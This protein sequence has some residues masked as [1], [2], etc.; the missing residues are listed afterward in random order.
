MINNRITNH[1]L[2]IPEIDKEHIELYKTIVKFKNAIS[3]NN[4]N[5]ASELKGE[6]FDKLAKHI[7]NE[8]RFM[9]K[10]NF[11]NVAQ[12]SQKHASLENNF[13]ITPVDKMTSYGSLAVEDELLYHIDSED[14]KIVPYYKEYIRNGRGK[15]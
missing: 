10:V 15:K 4:L 9:V 14:A 5:E 3:V 7:A 8:E 13:E 11:P 12:H 2:G 6:F 1:L